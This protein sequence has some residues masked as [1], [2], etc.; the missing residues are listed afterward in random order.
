MQRLAG[1]AD[2]HFLP[3]HLRSQ[4]VN[5][6]FVF[7]SCSIWSMA[8]RFPITLSELSRHGGSLKIVCRQC[9]RSARYAPGDL[10][11]W[12][13]GRGFRDDWATLGRHLVCKGIGEGCGA[14][15]PKITFEFDSPPPPPEKPKRLDAPPCPPGIDG[16]AWLKADDRERARMIGRL[17]G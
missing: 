5:A 8:R 11:R 2:G 9:G 3:P 12:L 17:R 15:W 13:R 7:A 1:V 6:C 14:R 16:E 4:I 10:G